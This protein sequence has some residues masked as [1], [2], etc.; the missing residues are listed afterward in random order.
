MWCEVN[1][2]Q[3]WQHGKDALDGESTYHEERTLEAMFYPA[4]KPMP[5][6][7][8]LGSQTRRLVVFTQVVSVTESVPLE[9]SH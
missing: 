4:Q 2:E 3:C 9:D 7:W 8:S 5:G 1:G 6:S